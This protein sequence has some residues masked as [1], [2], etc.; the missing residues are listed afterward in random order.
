MAISNGFETYQ[1]VLVFIF[2]TFSCTT[3]ISVIRELGRSYK[4]KVKKKGWGMGEGEVESS[5]KENNNNKRQKKKSCEQ[6]NKQTN[7]GK[8]MGEKELKFKH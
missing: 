8:K 2:S 1:S 5:S 6:T 7:K 3:R 4:V